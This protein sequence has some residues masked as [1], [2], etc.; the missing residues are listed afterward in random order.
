MGALAA[1]S[2]FLLAVKAERLSPI[3]AISMAFLGVE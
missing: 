2:H 1:Q 3:P